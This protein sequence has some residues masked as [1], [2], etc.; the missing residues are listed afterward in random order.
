LL[1]V[2]AARRIASDNALRILPC[3]AERLDAGQRWQRSRQPTEIRRVAA[4]P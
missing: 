1:S 3:L 4:P 2:G